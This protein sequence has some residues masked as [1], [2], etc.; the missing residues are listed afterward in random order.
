M[1]TQGWSPLLQQ[2][3]RMRLWGR[4]WHLH[5]HFGQVWVSQSITVDSI[6]DKLV[7][8]KRGLSMNISVRTATRGNHGSGKSLTSFW[9]ELLRKRSAHKIWV[10]IWEGVVRRQRA[11]TG[12][13]R[14]AIDPLKVHSSTESVAFVTTLL[15]H[16]QR[17]GRDWLL[18]QLR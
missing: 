18:K 12:F 3:A 7:H 10:F 17:K 13:K 2:V 8:G 11:K 16:I 5:W 9:G 14:V 15:G 6:L 4:D 1:K